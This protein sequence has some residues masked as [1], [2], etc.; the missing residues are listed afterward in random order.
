M[1]TPIRGASNKFT[2]PAQLKS[3]VSQSKQKSESKGSTGYSPDSTFEDV[4]NFKMDGFSA[5]RLDTIKKETL[6][7]MK[8]WL[9]KH[10]NATESEIKTEMK[11]QYDKMFGKANLEKITF[12]NMWNMLQQSIQRA[13]DE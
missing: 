8:D 12:D 5:T 11:S 3:E 4:N 2:V 10:P 6:D 7:G 13:Q 9:K 1:S